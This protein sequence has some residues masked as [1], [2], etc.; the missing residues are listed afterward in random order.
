MGYAL[1]AAIGAQ[2]VRPEHTVV[3]L[4]GDGCALMSLGDMALAAEL[5]L[6]LVVVVLNDD[7]LS[8]IKLKQRKMQL[9]PRA[10]DFR[11][12]RFDVLAAGFGAVGRRVT[13]LRDLEAALDDAVTSRRF[14]IIDALVDPAEYLEQM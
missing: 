13:T 11:S 12:P 4:V 8:L 6:P 2:L 3:A 1:P 5:D 9:D 14:T 10:V 7:A